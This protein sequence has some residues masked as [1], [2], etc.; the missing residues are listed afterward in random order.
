MV[1]TGEQEYRKIQVYY[2]GTAVVHGYT[3]AA[4]LQGYRGA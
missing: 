1:S 4:V 2:R 3:G